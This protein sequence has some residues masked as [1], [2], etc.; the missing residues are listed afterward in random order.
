VPSAQAKA[1]S[2]VAAKL[3]AAPFLLPGPPVDSALHIWTAADAQVAWMVDRL[4]PHALVSVISGASQ[5]FWHAMLLKVLA[6]CLCCMCCMC[7]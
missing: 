5:P 6:L 7:V 1:R 2:G 4:P 3:S